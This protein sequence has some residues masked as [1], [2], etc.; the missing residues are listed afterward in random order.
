[1][2]SETFTDSEGTF[3][4]NGVRA[5]DYR[6]TAGS[7]AFT[8]VTIDVR[9]GNHSIDLAATY[10]PRR[11]LDNFVELTGDYR[12]I[13]LVAG[14]G[15][16]NPNTNAWLTVEASYGNG[17]L[18]RLE[19][20]KQY[21]LN[22]FREFKFGRHNLTLFGGGY[23]G[24]SFVP[25]L[26]PINTFIPNDTVDDRQLDRTHNFMAVVTDTWNIDDKRQLTF[27]GFVREYALTLR[28][29]F[30]P[31]YSEQPLIGGLIQQSE[32]RTGVGA[33]PLY[34][35]EIRPWITLLAGMDFRRDA[36]RNLDLRSA[37]SQG[38]FHLVT[39]NS[40]TLT[41]A[42][43][44]VSVD[45]SL[46]KYFRYDVGFRREEVW[47]NNEDRINPQ[48]SFTKLA[49]LT[50][51]KATLAILSPDGTVL[52]SVALSYGEAFHTEDPRIGAGTGEPALLAPSRAYQLVLDKTVK[53]T[54]FR[55]TLRHVTNSQELAKIDP[56]TGLRQNVGPSINRVIIVSLQRTF[57]Q[58]SLFISYSQADGR[59][60]VSGEPVPEAPRLIWD[61]VATLNRLPFHLRAR[62]EFEYVRAKPL[63]DGFTGVA[64]PEFRGA[65]LR[66]FLD[67]R[68]T[69]STEFLIASGY[70]GQTTEVFAVPSDV[71]YPRPI[72][73]VV[74][75]PL[76]S[77]ITF[78]WAYHFGRD[79][80]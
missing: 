34:T 53:K 45:G 73:R 63:G 52:P 54:E 80:K 12:D 56:D 3:Q 51:P 14:W 69:L 8:T 40:L 64:V 2:L 44:F 72:E 30:N 33:C 61:A 70:T 74:G 55:V 17:F 60:R 65:V 78:S 19:H 13:D 38:A 62:S 4:F 79:S 48:R 9:E 28:S 42:E 46:G 27:S 41:F 5:G 39:S 31:D 35:H 10:V 20:R 50:L 11:H 23:Y 16:R 36:P 59:D 26:I 67:G 18:E 58:G 7:M 29:N 66:P 15:S 21:K 77:Y 43:P 76:K 47:M 37:D 32:S 1:L 24:F 22:G 6:L 75:V 71:T 25:G 49:G 68:M 57:S